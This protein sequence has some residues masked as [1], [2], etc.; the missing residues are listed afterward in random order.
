[1]SGT[2]RLAKAKRTSR[3]SSA[4]NPMLQAVAFPEL[5][6]MI[7]GTGS[8]LIGLPRNGKKDPQDIR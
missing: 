4:S 7:D 3:S 5:Q 1:M 2:F 8:L 6:S